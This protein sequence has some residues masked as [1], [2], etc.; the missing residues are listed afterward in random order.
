MNLFFFRTVHLAL[1]FGLATRT[2]A[3]W[4]LGCGKPVAI[5]RIDPI[6]SPDTLSNH[7]HS[8]MGGNAFDWDLDYNKTQT[9]NCTT[10]GVSKDLSNYWVPTVYFH[11]ENGSYISVE[12]VGGVNVYY[13]LAAPSPFVEKVSANKAPYRQR[14]DHTE[15]EAGKTIQP[16]PPGLRMLAGDPNRRTYNSTSLADRAIEYVCLPGNGQTGNATTGGFPDHTCLGGLQIRVRF[17]SC[18]DGKN[19]DSPDHRSH[20]AYPSM[21]DN[22]YCDPSHPVRIMALLYEVTWA[23]DHF[24]HLRKQPDQPFVLSTG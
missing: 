8:I 21:M 6:V 19:L 3:Y 1:V 18:W 20:V 10:C 14:I 17:P 15:I 13:Q 11:A 9:S 12:Q 24:D 7:V 23:V 4:V 5:E 22:G 16:F 2:T